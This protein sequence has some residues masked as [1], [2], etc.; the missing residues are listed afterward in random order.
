MGWG[1][2]GMVVGRC[3]GVVCAATS[4]SFLIIRD[5]FLSPLPPRIAPCDRLSPMLIRC[6]IGACNMMACLIHVFRPDAPLSGRRGRPA[7]VL[8]RTSPQVRPHDRRDRERSGPQWP[9]R[10]S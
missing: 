10:R 3:W 5:A 6:G 7:P 8:A 9:C 2:C 4:T 1:W